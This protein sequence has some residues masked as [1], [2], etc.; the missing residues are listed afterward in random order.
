MAV[1]CNSEIE[2]GSTWFLKTQWSN[3][4]PDSECSDPTDATVVSQS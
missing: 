2:E 1:L 4:H 3:E